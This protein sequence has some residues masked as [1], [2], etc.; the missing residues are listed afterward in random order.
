MH[1]QLRS[2]ICGT[3]LNKRRFELWRCCS[4]YPW[5]W[6]LLDFTQEYIDSTENI[7]IVRSMINNEIDYLLSF[8]QFRLSHKYND[9]WNST[10]EIEAF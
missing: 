6:E 3:H 2:I 5:N 9:W 10:L 7:A 8:H 4:E 1:Y